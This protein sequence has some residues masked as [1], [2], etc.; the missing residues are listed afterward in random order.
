MNYVRSV[1][2]VMFLMMAT[3][4]L[5]GD[6]AP[7]KGYLRVDVGIVL[8]TKDD[9]GKYRFFLVSSDKVRAI[10][11][12]KGEK[13]FV[14]SLGRGSRYNSGTIVAIPSKSLSS[15]GDD[16]ND[17]KLTQMKA[18]IAGD[19]LAGSIKLITHTFTR[20]VRVADAISI[21]DA[22]YRIDKTPTGLTAV[23]IGAVAPQAPANTAI[24]SLNKYP[25]YGSTIMA[26]ILMSL[27]FITVGFFGIRR[28]L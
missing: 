4:V 22:I 10:I 19:T 5:Y 9:L 25:S 26:G 17:E 23:P 1:A 21:S 3:G 7:A 8:E 6:I 13:A 27:T 28:T 20:D 14:G 11:I 18:A 16:P 24:G 2:A 12:K 15:F